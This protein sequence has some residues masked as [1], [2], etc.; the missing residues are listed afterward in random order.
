M[1]ADP[2]LM[3]SPTG[4]TMV[5]AGE[6]DIVVSQAFAE[7][8]DQ[9]SDLDLGVF[10]P[11]EGRDDPALYADQVRD[12]LERGLIET[13]SF[14]A[15]LERGELA[16]EARAVLIGSWRPR[17]GLHESTPISGRS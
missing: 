6:V 1:M 10:R 7:L 9:G 12:F 17:A 15:A 5:E 2:S 13:F 8:L 14:E 11:D 3:L 4:Q 16:D